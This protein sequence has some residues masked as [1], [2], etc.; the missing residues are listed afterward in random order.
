M[1]EADHSEKRSPAA[2]AQERRRLLAQLDELVDEIARTTDERELEALDRRKRIT[3][4]KVNKMLGKVPAGD[5]KPLA[6]PHRSLQV[7]PRWRHGQ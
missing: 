4:A 7:W 5:Y 3:E 2:I 1:I 6:R